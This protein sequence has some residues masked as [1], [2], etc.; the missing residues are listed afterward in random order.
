[1]IS[2]LALT[3]ALSTSAPLQDV[4]PAPPLR[5][6]APVLPVAPAPV[7]VT[8]I[9]VSLVV[10]GPAMRVIQEIELTNPASFPQEFDLIFPLGNGSVIGGL[11]LKT[12][13]GVRLEGQVFDA[14]AAR[15]IYM[16]ITRRH[17]DPALLEHYGE[18]MYRARVSPVPAQGTQKL[19]LSY[20]RMVELEG[21]LLRLHLP[22]SAFRRSAGPL[23]LTI[24]GDITA[25]SPITTLYSPTHSLDQGLLEELGGTP[26]RFRTT[27]TATQEASDASLDFLAFYKARP[28]GGFLDVSV[29]SERPNPDEDGY[30]LVVIDG[31]PGDEVE[32]EP[33]DVVF[34]LDRSGSMEGKK[35]EQARAALKF[36]VERLAPGDRFNLISYAAGVEV[37]SAGFLEPTADNIAAARTFI[38]GVEAVGGTNIEEAL[39]TAVGLFSSAERVNQV[40]F[41]TD[42]LPTVGERDHRVICRTVKEQN[43]HRARV[44]AFGVGFDVNGTFLDRL[45]VGN[46]GM[47]EY[48]LPSENIEDK[49]PGFYSR[50]R[51][52]L[53]LD[54]TLEIVGAQ[55]YDLFP[56]EIGDLYGGHQILLTGRY[57]V[58]SAATIDASA[59]ENPKPVG[60]T[61]T[62]EPSLRIT[63][64]RGTATLDLGFPLD[65]A[66]DNRTGTRDLVA[67]MWA[68][69]K[70]G[71]LIDEIRLEGEDDE[72]VREIVRLGTR[73]GILTEYTSFL[74][75]EDTD[76]LALGA[77]FAT[78]LNLVDEMARVEDGTQG[79]SQAA[80]SKTR[81]RAAQVETTNRWY[82]KDGKLVVERGVK[83]IAGK[84]F[85]QRGGAWVDSSCGTEPADQEVEF[86]SAGYFA[87]LDE[88]PWLAAV[89]ARTG[90]VTVE[91]A[92]KRVLLK[93]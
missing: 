57:R 54:T 82:D 69:K 15:A 25:P 75:A 31:V 83:C 67:R 16:E 41:L 39:A 63:G 30:F 56:R 47:S 62:P 22:L 46:R 19:V 78:C 14:V 81:Q 44:V 26:P 21:D 43:A 87:L 71:F 80:N 28:A 24:K 48:V 37:F 34:V 90:E 3:L 76:L 11:G 85:F 60:L 6:V 13:D 73:F 40:V 1:M 59:T 45:A 23:A 18:G 68:A 66:V 65:L 88:N 33:K 52:P 61:A 72:L 10:D 53:L 86:C 29:L 58:P 36:L 17:L 38:D 20:T 84:T 9:D 77:N 8:A 55:V 7:R 49:V 4:E 64:R 42:G 93:G 51:N 92:G 74:A 79:V 35:I 32:P 5:P 2:A 70:V 12:G 50:M 91:I 27:F 89:V